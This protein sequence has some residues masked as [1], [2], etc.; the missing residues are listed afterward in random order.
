MTSKEMTA[1][2]CQTAVT[3]EKSPGVLRPAVDIYENDQGMVLK[4]DLP[5]VTLEQLEVQVEDGLLTLSATSQAPNVERFH[6]REFEP[7]RFQRTFR[8][9]DDIDP[10]GIEAELNLGVLTLSLPKAEAAKAR[11]I[12]IKTVH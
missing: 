1:Q 3:K 2:G 9:S 7:T 10:A 12:E 5:G 8:L 11:K 6:W 4:A